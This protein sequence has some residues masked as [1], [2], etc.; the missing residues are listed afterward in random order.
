MGSF[1]T[2]QI[3]PILKNFDWVLAAPVFRDH[4]QLRGLPKPAGS[5]RFFR[6]LFRL[7]KK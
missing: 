1:P 3:D 2:T 7:P 6:L 5:R 4:F